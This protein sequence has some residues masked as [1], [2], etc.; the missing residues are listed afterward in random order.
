MFDHTRR[1][2]FRGDEEKDLQ[3][4]VLALTQAEAFKIGLCAAVQNTGL[5]KQ[6]ADYLEQNDFETFAGQGNARVKEL[7]Q[8]LGCNYSCVHAIEEEVDAILYI[9]DG[10]FHPIGISFISKKRL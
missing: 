1:D 6:V 7:G 8:V 2:L 4:L 10:F 3:K 5:L 9:G